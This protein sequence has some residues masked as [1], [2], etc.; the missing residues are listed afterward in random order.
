[1][2]DGL[3][4]LLESNP[5]LQVIAAVSGRRQAPR[6]SAAGNRTVASRTGFSTALKTGPYLFV[7]MQAPLAR[8]AHPGTDISPRLISFSRPR[9][10]LA[11]MAMCSR[12]TAATICFADCSA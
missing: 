1:M 3:V 11:L 12:A 6:P 8:S 9:W 4:A 2:R 10:V 5:T 7:L